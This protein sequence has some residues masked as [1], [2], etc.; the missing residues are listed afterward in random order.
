MKKFLIITGCVALAVVVISCSD[1]RREP[2]RAYMPDMAYSTA[3]ETYAPAQERLKNSG[4][5]GEATYNGRPVE[6]TIARGEMMPYTL[7]ND[8][9][10]YALSANVKNPL[11]PASD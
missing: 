2:G 7:K 5:E 9:L 11:A 10:G 4:V 8:S 3:Y 1:T 6:G